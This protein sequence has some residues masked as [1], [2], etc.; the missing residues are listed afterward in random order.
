MCALSSIQS[1]SAPVPI[2]NSL[3][4][5]ENRGSADGSYD[6]VKDSSCDSIQDTTLLG[7]AMSTSAPSGPSPY[8]SLQVPSASKVDDHD[9]RDVVHAGSVSGI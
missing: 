6:V 9:D 2:Y 4:L 5:M 8:A 7:M 1:S 3:L